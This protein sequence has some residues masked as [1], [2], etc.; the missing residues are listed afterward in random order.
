MLDGLHGRKLPFQDWPC[1]LSDITI[2][3]KKG[4][5]FNLLMH[6][7]QIRTL[8]RVINA[9]LAGLYN[10]LLSDPPRV[11]DAATATAAPYR[12]TSM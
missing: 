6:T 7:M 1:L 10:Q 4:F 3:T 2:N 11:N 9:I 8:K 5:K 12:H